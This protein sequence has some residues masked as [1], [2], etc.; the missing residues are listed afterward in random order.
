MKTQPI[1]LNTG[2][3]SG[4]ITIHAVALATFTLLRKAGSKASSVPNALQSSVRDIAAAWVDS[5]PK[6]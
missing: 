1:R 2:K 6:A 3:P 5:R 4:G